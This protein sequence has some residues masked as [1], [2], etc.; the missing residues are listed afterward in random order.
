M[1][2]RP[3][4]HHRPPDGRGLLHAALRSRQCDEPTLAVLGLLRAT[5]L[6]SFWLNGLPAAERDLRLGELLAGYWLPASP[7]RT[8]PRSC[9]NSR[10]AGPEPDVTVMPTES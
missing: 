2:V 8:C 3:R 1:V 5:G 4:D 7:I 6:H 10:Q 9:D